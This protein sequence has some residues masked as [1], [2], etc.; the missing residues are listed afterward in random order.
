MSIANIEVCVTVVDKPLLMIHM[1]RFDE[2]E[3]PFDIIL[4]AV[5]VVVVAVARDISK[6]NLR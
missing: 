5:V 2:V 4:Y 1:P 6:T 3:S